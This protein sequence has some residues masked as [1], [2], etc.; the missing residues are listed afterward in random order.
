M[1]SLSG[2]H[3]KTH[4]RLF[5]HPIALNVHLRDVWAMFKAMTDAKAVD[6][7]DG[8]LK[9]TRHGRSLVLRHCRGEEMADRETVLKIRHFLGQL[10]DSVPPSSPSLM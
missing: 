6:D 2:V 7:G 5:E 8:H 9:V 10:A 1:E 3:Q 4:D